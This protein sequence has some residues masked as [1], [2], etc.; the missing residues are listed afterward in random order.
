MKTMLRIALAPLMLA[1]RLMLGAAAFITSIAGSIIGLTVSI[2]ALL[3]VIEFCIGYWQNGIAFFA[4]AWL[5][6]PI[7][8]PGIANLLLNVLDRTIGFFEGLLAG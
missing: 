7:G 1:I 5:A 3:G 6:S 8:L 4:L 2:F